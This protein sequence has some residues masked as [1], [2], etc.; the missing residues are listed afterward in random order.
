[1]QLRWSWLLSDDRANIDDKA[2]S[3]VGQKIQPSMIV[4]I[5]VA[6]RRYSER[7]PGGIVLPR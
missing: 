3:G 2:G 6:F 1:M 5:A 4:N 7:T